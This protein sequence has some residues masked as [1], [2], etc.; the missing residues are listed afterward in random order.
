VLLLPVLQGVLSMAREADPKGLRTLGVL[1]K[2]D[3]VEEGCHGQWVQVLQG[4]R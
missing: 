3:Q 4:K 1:T 2:P